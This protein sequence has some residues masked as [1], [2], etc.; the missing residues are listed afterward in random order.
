MHK[1]DTCRSKQYHLRWLLKMTE[2]FVPDQ[3]LYFFK[4]LQVFLNKSK[5]FLELEDRIG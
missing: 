5:Y 2:K 1:K 4:L 3:E